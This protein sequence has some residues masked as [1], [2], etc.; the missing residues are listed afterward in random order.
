VLHLNQKPI[1]ALVSSTCLALSAYSQQTDPEKL[2]DAGHWIRARAIV[3]A[4][5]H[6]NPDD[7]LSNFLLSQ[8]RN[9]FGDYTS[10]LGLAEKA[11]AL[12]GRVAKYH[13]Q[14]AEVLG[15]EAQHAGPVK[16]V[17][18][19]HRFRGEIDTAIGLDPRD[20]QTQR[21]LL[22]YYLVA[23]GIA[24]GDVQKAMVSAQHIGELDAAEG[25]LAKARIASFR[26]QTAETEA[27]LRNAAWS[28]PPSYRAHVELAKFYL[29]PEHSN[30]AVAEGV[31]KDLLKLDRERV[32][33]YVFLAQVYADRDDWNALD[34]VLAGDAEQCPDDLAPYYRAAEVLLGHGRDPARAESYLRT[35]LG[36]E[37]EG[38][39][40]PVADARQKL[41][42]T[43][44]LQGNCE[45]GHC[46]EKS[47]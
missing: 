32:E 8:I 42:T 30:P 47:H 4:R 16:I 21:D 7:S 45:V 15:V 1:L 24:G 12:D 39:E 19:A 46:R 14:L 25:Y 34:A 5:L 3:E 2:I 26:K 35:Y 36:R 28:Q 10:P 38:N 33:P 9:A 41:A 13:R 11:V 44:A 23:P 18:L 29:A 43:R 22:E 31:A 27:L 17:F 6:Q 37:P 20:V 40:P